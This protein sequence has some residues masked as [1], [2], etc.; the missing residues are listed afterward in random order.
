MKRQENE[1]LSLEA[2]RHALALADAH[3]RGLGDAC[4][5]YRRRA[6]AR[7]CLLLAALLVAATLSASAAV[8]LAAGR[9][10]AKGA[11]STDG[12]VRCVQQILSAV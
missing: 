1:E 4:R 5:G 10:A 11:L 2:R 7:R 8:S 12:A 6:A 9:P 3:A